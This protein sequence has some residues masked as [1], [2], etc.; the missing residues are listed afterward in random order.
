MK[1][2]KNLYSRLNTMDMIY[3][4]PDNDETLRLFGELFAES[5]KDV[6][7]IVYNGLEYFLYNE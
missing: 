5:Y 1:T 4:I 2:Y 7:K 3:T 6:C